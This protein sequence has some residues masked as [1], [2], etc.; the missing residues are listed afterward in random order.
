MNKKNGFLPALITIVV[1]YVLLMLFMGV[2]NLIISGAIIVFLVGGGFFIYRKKSL[3]DCIVAG[4][5]DY[6]GSLL[7]TAVVLSVLLPLFFLKNHYIIHIF[8][9]ALIYVIASVGLNIQVGSANMTNF[10]QGAFFGIGAYTSALMTVKLGLSFWIAFPSAV[11]VAGI[12]GFLMGLPTLKTREFHLSLVTIAFAYV[13]YLLI[14]NMRWTGGADGIAGV[15]KPTIFG[16]SIFKTVRLGGLR[17][18]WTTFYYYFTL[19][20]VGIGIYFAWKLHNSWIALGWNAIRE[21][22][23]SSK[24]YGLDLNKIKLSAFFIG[25]LY[26][27]AAGSLYVHFVGFISTESMAFSVG[28][29]MVCMVILGGM[30]NILGVILGTVL[31]IVIP[32]KFR[33]FQDFRLL[34]YGIILILMLI[35]RPQGLIPKKVRRY[36][37]S[38]GGDHG[39]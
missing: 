33:A 27:G 20:F 15:P 13:A 2:D 32:E 25:S 37:L 10:S 16:L 6:K 22:E 38:T 35:F 23:I 11:L 3:L 29:L 14:L 19:L 24:C 1:S 31:L 5:R 17:I 4:F 30:D 7:I 34:F 9:L 36:S 18:P 39:K 12:F 21:D 28:L 8:T 26:A